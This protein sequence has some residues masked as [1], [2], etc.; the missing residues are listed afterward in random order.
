MPQ[1]SDVRNHISLHSLT[2]KTFMSVIA[3][4][5]RLGPNRDIYKFKLTTIF[6]E[7]I[8]FFFSTPGICHAYITVLSSKA[9]TVQF[10]SK[11]LLF[12]FLV[13]N[14][15]NPL[16]RN[17]RLGALNY[18]KTRGAHCPPMVMSWAPERFL[19]LHQKICKKAKR[20]Q[21]PH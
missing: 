19:G 10:S 2:V 1:K 6:Y 11:Q 7:A 20:S 21:V 5:M 18:S 17:K 14:R 13:G 15:L 9:V 3:S 12:C 8:R 16:P 4:L